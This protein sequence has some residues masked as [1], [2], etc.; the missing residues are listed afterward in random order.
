MYIYNKKLLTPEPT[1]RNQYNYNDVKP[2]KGDNKPRDRTDALNSY[3]NVS[4]DELTIN[5]HTPTLSNYE[6]TPTMENTIMSM[7]NKIQI[8]RDL[9]PEIQ[10]KLTLDN[11]D[12]PIIRG[13]QQLKKYDNIII[14]D[15]QLQ[16]PLDTLQNNPY[17]NDGRLKSEYPENYFNNDIR[18]LPESE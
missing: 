8:N 15:H 14:Y 17:I 16:Y 5:K 4:K 7:K 12:I 6:K 11:K 2:A 13:K 10:Q 3:V 9:I 18:G 1:N